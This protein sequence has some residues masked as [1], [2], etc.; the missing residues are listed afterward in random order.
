MHCFDDGADI[1]FRYLANVTGLL[2][3][4]TCSNAT[5][6]DTTLVALTLAGQ[7]VECGDDF[8]NTKSKITVAIEAGQELIL[9]VAGFR[10]ATGMGILNVQSSNSTCPPWPGPSVCP[11]TYNASCMTINFVF[12][13]LIEGFGAQGCE[14]GPAF[15]PARCQPPPV[16]PLPPCPAPPT[17]PTKCLTFNLQFGSLLAAAD[18]RTPEIVYT[19]RTVDE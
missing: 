9:R 19:N 6:F 2:E 5:D 12:E 13:G 18:P 4:D 1:F 11:L 7:V 15:V 16:V 14:C 3:I 17:A 10:R 8:C